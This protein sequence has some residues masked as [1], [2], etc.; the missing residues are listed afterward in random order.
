MN[1]TLV[2][3]EN[4]SKKFCRDLK[5]SLW[6]GTK[7]LGNEL[8]GLP[9]S[10]EGQ[11]RKDEFWA[12]K[13]VSFEL[14]RGEC[15]GLIGR[16]GA[17]KTTLLRMLNGLIKPD[18]G[19]I[20]MHGRVGALIALGAGFN[21]ILTGR[22]NIYVNAA[23]LGLSKKEI[24]V[25]FEKIVEFAELGEFIDA[26]VQSY[27]SGMTVRLGFAVATALEPDI[28]IIDEVLA[29][30]DIG[31]V[32]KCLNRI[33][34]LLSNTSVI[35]VSHNMLHVSRICTHTLVINSGKPIYQNSDVAEAINVY[36]SL[37]K[38][39]IGDFI[40]SNK[41]RLQA[42]TLASGKRCAAGNKVL[43]VKYGEELKINLK[44]EI[45]KTISEPFLYMA[46]Y[47]KEQRNFAEIYSSNGNF[48]IE[49]ISGLIA[50]EAV[51]PSINFSQGIYS[52]T[53]AFS[54]RKGGQV[55]FRQQSAIYFQVVGSQHGWA[56]IQ[57]RPIWR[58][59]YEIKEENCE[60]TH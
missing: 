22:E 38:N 25:K 51:I 45:D 28:L 49:N 34:R 7:D 54:E 44:V 8:L 33:D 24:D 29:V 42:I 58:Q 23:V 15:L 21:P 56:P 40:G 20:E 35:F 6:Y 30:G 48:V 41:A 5:R 19:R 46:F 17:G 16:N 31:F 60:V 10:G 55:I 1:N 52:V 2:K 59:L 36:Y 26:P 4:I 18:M 9:L 3:V 39:K 11:L 53:V 43:S 47:D 13:D 37:F 57:I 27:S 14:K 12:V 50:I 32:L